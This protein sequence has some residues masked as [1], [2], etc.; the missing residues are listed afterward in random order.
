MSESGTSYSIGNNFHFP[1]IRVTKTIAIRLLNQV[2]TLHLRNLHRRRLKPI[3]QL[4]TSQ[5]SRNRV[6]RRPI[7]SMELE[8][9]RRSGHIHAQHHRHVRG[10]LGDTLRRRDRISRQSCLHCRRASI[11]VVEQR[12]ESISNLAPLDRDRGGSSM[13]G[14]HSETSHFPTRR[15]QRP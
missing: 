11:S 4:R 14:R 1:K 2:L 9:R 12:C 6:R 13:K 10:S 7:K 8:E 5:N 3:I 15:H